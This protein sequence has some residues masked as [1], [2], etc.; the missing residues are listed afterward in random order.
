MLL[1]V[2]P[3]RFPPCRAHT[4]A[5]RTCSGT[6]R[7]GT[8][9]TRSTWLWLRSCR[10]S[11]H[12][13]ALS[14]Q[15]QGVSKQTMQDTNTRHPST[16]AHRHLAGACLTVKSSGAICTQPP[17][18]A[19]KTKRQHPPSLDEVPGGHSRHFSDD[20]ASLYHP[21]L[22]GLHMLLP[23]VD[24]SYPSPQLWQLV[25]PGAEAKVFAA[26]GRHSNCPSMS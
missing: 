9:C 6:F 8:L 24:T 16:S 12:C 20:A 23:D 19:T 26:Q 3:G 4:P 18:Q 2:R 10:A 14:L 17:D 1:H 15:Q 7:V 22:H 13:T 5:D 25:E 11:T 21:A